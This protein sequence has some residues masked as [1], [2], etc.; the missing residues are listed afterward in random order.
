MTKKK[1]VQVVNFLD[2][3]T[4][5]ETAKHYKISEMTISRYVKR[6]NQINIINSETY[7]NLLKKGFI[8]LLKKSIYD[9]S[10][11]ELKMIL[12]LISGKSISCTKDQYISKIKKYTGIKIE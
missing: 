10:A 7:T 5:K 3:H 4:W 1:I 6:F 11:V 12:Y 2:K 9:M 8:N